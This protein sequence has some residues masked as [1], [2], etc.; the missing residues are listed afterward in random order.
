M[1]ARLLWEQDVAGSNPVIPTKIGFGKQFSKPFSL[2][3]ATQILRADDSFSPALAFYH[4]TNWNLSIFQD[5]SD[6]ASDLLP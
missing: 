6:N 2:F 5:R 4:L 1:V 3:S